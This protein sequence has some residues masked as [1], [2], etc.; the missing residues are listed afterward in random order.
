[1]LTVDGFPLGREYAI[2]HLLRKA[3]A[4]YQHSYIEKE[5][6]RRHFVIS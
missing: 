4:R 5:A 6:Y 2:F 3:F 1:V